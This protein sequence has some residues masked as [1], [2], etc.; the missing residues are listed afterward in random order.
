MNLLEDKKGQN[1]YLIVL[2]LIVVFIIYFYIKS[3]GLVP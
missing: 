1:P 2:V 3:K